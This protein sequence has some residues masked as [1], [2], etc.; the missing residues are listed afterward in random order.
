MCIR[1]REYSGYFTKD[2]IREVVAYADDNY[3]EVIPEFDMPG[4][5]LSVLAAYPEL[6]CKGKP[7][8][9]GTK[10]GIFDD[11]LC[12]GND[13]SLKLVFDVLSEMIELFPGRY[14]HIGGDEASKQGWRTC[15]KC[16]ARMRKEGLKDVDELQSYM[17]R[18]IETFLNAKGRRL[19]GWDEILE[20]GLAPDATVMSWR[21]TEGGIAA[22]AHKLLKQ[23]AQFVGINGQR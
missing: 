22:A 6:S 8:E 16:A 23:L 20:G 19:L 11:I 18:R 21:G 9:V 7:L 2:E 12:A 1:D 14:F 17:I 10:Q 4:H 15:P 3:I 13:D 5:T